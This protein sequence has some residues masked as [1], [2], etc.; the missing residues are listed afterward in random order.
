MLLHAH[1]D[2]LRVR[3]LVP[4]PLAIFKAGH[5]KAALA[6]S[7]SRTWAVLYDHLMVRH[8]RPLCSPPDAEARASA[9][10]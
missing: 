6:L 10:E 1:P 7:G 2:G 9:K 8:A 5:T 3:P 4:A